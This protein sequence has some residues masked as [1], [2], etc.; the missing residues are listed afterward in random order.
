MPNPAITERICTCGFQ[1]T[2]YDHGI[3]EN[4]PGPWRKGQ[5]VSFFKG[6]DNDPDDAIMF[7]PDCD[8]ELE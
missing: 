2:E 7:C 4:P 6:D 8:E 1:F 5:F 3:D